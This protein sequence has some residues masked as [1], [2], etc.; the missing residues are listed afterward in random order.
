MPFDRRDMLLKEENIP[1]R[2][3]VVNEVSL[4][5]D[6]DEAA[7][8]VALTGMRG[9]KILQDKFFTPRMSIERLLQKLGP[10]KHAEERGAVRELRYLIDFVEG[11][12]KKGQEAN[13]D[14]ETLRKN[15][16]VT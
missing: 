1:K 15:R 11:R 10:F 2:P 14:L 12:I 7:A 5:G 3:R 9:W 13:S 4:L 16:E 6:V 8:L